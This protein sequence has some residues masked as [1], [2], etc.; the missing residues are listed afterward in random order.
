MALTAYRHYRLLFDLVQFTAIHEV[1]MY[2]TTT[3][4]GTNLLT[5]S[6]ASSSGH[7]SSQTPSLAIDGNA[8]TYFE[9][10]TSSANRWISFDLGSAQVVRSIK[11]TCSITNETVKSFY[12]QGST[13]GTNWVTLGFFPTFSPDGSTYSGRVQDLSLY[14]GGNSTTSAGGA[15]T[16][17][18]IYTWSTGAL[19]ASVTP[20][21]NGDWEWRLASSS[22]VLVTHIGP[23]GY[24][25]ISDGPITPY[26]G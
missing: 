7:W 23:S 5:G 21:T 13:D 3:G 2:D 17:V 6:T 26:M 9:T 25:P 8:S 18:L 20:L 22:D 19:V 15:A 1:G 4:T 12:F 14:V 10:A 11:L 16:R 24:Q